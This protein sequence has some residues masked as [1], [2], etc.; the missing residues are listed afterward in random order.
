MSNVEFVLDVSERSKPASWERMKTSHFE[1]RIALGVVETAQGRD[2]STQRELATFHN[3]IG[4][5]WLV[6]PADCAGA[7]HPPGD[8]RP[9]LFRIVLSHSQKAYSEVVWRQTTESFIRCLENAFRYFGGVPRT[10]IPD[11][12]RAAV[13]RADWYD[14]ATCWTINFNN[15]RPLAERSLRSDFWFFLFM[16]FV[17]VDGSGV[18]RQACQ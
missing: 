7:G 10:L 11:N 8:G 9:H 5:E 15:S 1:E 3:D 6:A 17:L 12:L 18:H 2:E 14:L 16:N 13:T 4:G